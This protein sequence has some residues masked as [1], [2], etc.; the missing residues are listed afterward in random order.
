M[1]QKPF[2]EYRRILSD[3]PAPLIM[4]LLDLHANQEINSAQLSNLIYVVNSYLIRRALCDLDTSNI[5][6][7]FPPLLKDVLDECNG[8]YSNI[9]DILKKNLVFK[10][11]NN[12]MFVPDDKQLEDIITN[13]NM[14]KTKFALRLI[15]DKLEHYN[16]PAPVDLTMLSVEHLMPQTPTAEWYS[17]LGVDKEEYQRN[18]NRLGN[19]TLA[20]KIDNSKM[21]NKVW[22]YK[23]EILSKTAHLVINQE[24]LEND[25]WDIEAID[26]RTKSLIKSINKLFPYPEASSNII[27]TE[28]IFLKSGDRIVAE[29]KFYLDNGAVEIYES[30]ELCDFDY[31]DKYPEIDQERQNLLE[32]GFVYDD[33]GRLVF[34]KDYTM[35]SKKLNSTALSSSASL[36]LG[37]SKNGWRCWVDKNDV[38][39]R[40]KREIKDLFV[41]E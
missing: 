3:M 19:L 41:S 6:R 37:G 33:N 10:N 38:E 40:H 9:V 34:K 2:Q 4:G 5:T 36:I 32:D 28:E 30:S 24:I 20:S 31:E 16:N 15:L 7:M 1:L 18:V 11:V 25:R 26:E 22:Q 17:E 23:N 12:G 13:A 21:Q 14:Y 27:N 39:L 8:D 29:A 35:Y